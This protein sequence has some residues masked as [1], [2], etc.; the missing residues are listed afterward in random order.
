MKSPLKHSIIPSI[1]SHIMVTPPPTTIILFTKLCLRYRCCICAGTS[2]LQ[3]L[4]KYISC[5]LYF[6]L[7]VQNLDAVV[8]DFTITSKRSQEVLFAQPF[9][10]SGLVAVVPLKDQD[11]VSLDWVFTKPFTTEMWLLMAGF[12][13]SGGMVVYI[14]ERRN[15]RWFRGQPSKQFGSILW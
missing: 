6:F 10:D 11:T 8:G 2:R 5:C 4:L 15:N 3:V 1:T 13:I 7:A 14:L 9:L 12:F